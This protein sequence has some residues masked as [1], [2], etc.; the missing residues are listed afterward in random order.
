[1]SG[2]GALDV[3]RAA[4]VSRFDFG[5]VRLSHLIARICSRRLLA[6]ILSLVT[7]LNSNMMSYG[8]EPTDN[9]VAH[10][11]IQ[12]PQEKLSRAADPGG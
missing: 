10:C 8:V 3:R 9:F 12:N 7:F 2:F 5:T 11:L 1:V 6:A 4:S